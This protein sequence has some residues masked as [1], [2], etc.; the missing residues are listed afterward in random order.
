[1]FLNGRLFIYHFISQDNISNFKSH[2]SSSIFF[3]LAIEPILLLLCACLNISSM[4]SGD[5]AFSISSLPNNAIP[6][7]FKNISFS[8]LEN[9]FLSERL[10]E[11]P[12]LLAPAFTELLLNS[13]S[14]CLRS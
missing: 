13:F 1:V 6:S 9:Q 8:S 10:N 12:S 11:K 2:P 4:A 5:A 3:S 7:V 14:T